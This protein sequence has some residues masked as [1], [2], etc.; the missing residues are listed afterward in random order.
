MSKSRI[1][2][3]ARPIGVGGPI[4]FLRNFS[5]ALADLD[6]EVIHDPEAKDCD[7]MLIINGT[8][9]LGTLVRHKKR[10]IRIVQRLGAIHWQHRY[11]FT[12][13]RNYMLAEIRNL[14]M[15][16]IRRQ[17]ADHVIYQSQFSQNWW[18]DRYGKTDCPSTV[19]FNGVDLDVFSPKG[20][21]SSDDPGA[22][23]LSAEGSQ[24]AD[25][26]QIAISLARAISEVENDIRLVL[27]GKLWQPGSDYITNDPFVRFVGQVPY[28]DMPKYYRAA[29]IFVSTDVIAACPNSVIESLACGTPVIGFSEGALP[30][31]VSESVGAC[32]DYGADAF[33]LQPPGNMV[34][35]VR[36]AIK[37]LSDPK[38][39]RENAR[40]LAVQEY[41]LARMV[42]RYSEVLWN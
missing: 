39:F 15:R 25:R 40:T 22:M 17:I 18:E 16:F 26:H 33:E 31:L 23:V 4:T 21:L 41:S 34:G 9:R 14:I 28:S 37:I 42:E 10:G 6:V 20:P 36:A 13:A 29:D 32:V 2:I 7:S 8:R 24:G 35:L 11:W 1:C 19:I 38:S 27:V 12:G 5:S 3:P 30:E